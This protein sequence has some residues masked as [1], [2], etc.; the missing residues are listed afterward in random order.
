ML[1]ITSKLYGC[2]AV[3]TC[4]SVPAVEADVLRDRDIGPL[5]GIFG[6]PDSTEG[7][8]LLQRGVSAWE[9]SITH[10]SH[11]INDVR[12][13]EALYLDGETSRIEFR[14]RI[15]LSD[16]LEIGVEIPYVQHQRGNLDAVIDSFHDFFGMPEGHRP[17]RA[18]DVLDFRYADATGLLIS[19][20][21]GASGIGDVRLFG[22][23]RLQTSDRHQLALR[24]GA[25][26]ASGDSSQLQGSGGTDLSIGLAGDVNGLFGVER[27]GGFYRLHAIHMGEPDLLADRYR[28]WTS[29]FSAGF[30]YRASDRVELMLQGAS[31]APIYD[32]A[33]RNLG[34]SAT[35]ITFGGNVRLNDRF[36]L[37][38]GISEDVDVSSA[39]DVAFQIALRYRRSD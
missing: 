19:M 23:W 34:E 28:S 35:T 11:S 15:G 9:F 31:R 13:G 24:F 18:H 16:R 8:Q 10:A 27:L 37:S 26:F 32:S 25:K 7:A 29:F 17:D 3:L 14:Y 21:Q 38:L 39:P 6:I 36:R 5:T 2:I 20:R 33:V 12:P 22:G 30:G 4:L 1:D